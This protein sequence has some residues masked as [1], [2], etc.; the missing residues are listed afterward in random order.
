[1]NQILVT[2]VEN[3]GQDG[4]MK[5]I[6]RFFCIVC[7]VFSLILIGEAGFNLYKSLSNK[8]SSTN[9]AQNSDSAYTP[10]KTNQDGDAKPELKMEKNGSS[11]NLIVNSQVG[12]NKVIYKWNNGNETAVK[13]DGKKDF[14]FDVEIPQGDNT[15]SVSM[16]DVNGNKTKFKDQK[17]SF[18]SADD[19]KKPVISIENRD[20]KLYVTAM[21]ETE[22]DYFS[23]QWEGQDEVVVTPT[24]ED[25]KV[26]KQELE[27]QQGTTRLTLVAVD[28]TG[29]KEST[30]KKI[31]GS[32]GPAIKASI[33][34]GNFVVNVTDE[35]GI[36]KIVYTHNEE[37]VE[38]EDIPEGATEYEFR[39]PL[40][41]G[42][43]YLK[44]NAYENGIMTEYKCKKTK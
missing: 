22:L 14:D 43:N 19:T 3:K 42:A 6:I 13:A 17:V 36:T 15:L 7:I 5:P 26:I 4:S 21:D 41:D 12:I 34:E 30:T 38:V 28:K 18:T 31:I 16:I 44:I 11:V 1:M 39:V 27:V 37:E 25:N 40:K 35:F 8:E 9:N 33:S 2:D 20:G 10:A 24:E 23:Y 29:N 32:N